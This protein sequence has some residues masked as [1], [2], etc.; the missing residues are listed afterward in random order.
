[1]SEDIKHEPDA[2]DYSA[3]RLVGE[4]NASAVEKCAEMV[5]VRLLADVS[6]FEDEETYDKVFEAIEFDIVALIEWMILHPEY[7]KVET[8]LGA[9]IGIAAQYNHRDISLDWR[10]DATLASAFIDMI[11][12]NEMKETIDQLISDAVKEAEEDTKSPTSDEAE[13]KS[14]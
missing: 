8:L 7:N 9:F 2:I 4:D 11:V 6:M 5:A 3:M 10:L 12:D 14:D 1:M 13:A